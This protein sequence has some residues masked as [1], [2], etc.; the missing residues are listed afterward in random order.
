MRVSR[1]RIAPTLLALCLTAC[2]GGGGKPESLDLA[3]RNLLLVSI[4]TLRADHTSPYGHDI[5]TPA[6]QRLADEGVVFEAAQSPVPM[7]QPA[8]TSLFTGQY[9]GRHGV[10]DNA[11]TMLTDEAVTLAEVLLDAG[12]QTG[13]VVAAKV[14]A[15]PTGLDQGFEFYDD[16][17]PVES[18]DSLS[19]KLERRAREVRLSAQQW[20]T[21]R[22]RARPFALFVHFYDVHMP[23][24]PPPV[25][26][27]RYPGR[28]L[29]GEIAFV[30]RNL[31]ALLEQLEVEGELERTLVI[32][33]SDHGE[34]LGEHDEDEHGLFLYEA[35]SHVPLIVRLPGAD[36]PRGV[37]VATP[38]TLVDVMPT[39]L[40]LLGLETPAGDGL[41]LVPL[42]AG[43]ELA[44]RP[45]LG[46]T[47]YPLFYRWAPSYS[48]R[49]EHWKFILAPRP[50]LYD[51]RRDPTELENLAATQA[52]RAQGMRVA[53][54]RHVELWKDRGGTAEAVGNLSLQEL[55]ALGYGGGAP[56]DE[57]LA[58][59]LP[60]VKDR[61]DLY[62][63]QTAVLDSL[64][65]ARWEE[66]CE[67]L[68]EVLEEDPTNTSALLNMGT[69]LA[70]LGRYEESELHLKA[71]LGLQPDNPYALG[72]LAMG[73]MAQQR[74]DEAEDA[75]CRILE[76]SPRKPEPRFFLGQVLARRGDFAG[77]LECFEAV[78]RQ[79]PD[80]PMLQESLEGSRRALQAQGGR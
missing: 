38:V 28:P 14:M 73:Y 16:H 68:R 59:E 19:P 24:D 57:A 45:V 21:E 65:N 39:V 8:H 3:G 11:G 1:L 17:F 52:E 7:T 62:R 78:Q 35:T 55:A 22:D 58:G 37:R 33:L 49:D 63:R 40:E 25:F 41:S 43:G 50:E 51:L 18:L 69:A 4:D 70:R 15:A 80:M 5:E 20:L 64:A 61:T 53:L 12:Y 27:E 48:L 47:L 60:D 26:R 13:A 67:G 10:R 36:A 9:P 56:V 30:D 23:H 79:Q 34:S 42:L 75:L 74:L 29:D 46:E 2:G 31:E 54:E 76:L 72:T 71:C 6:L 66:A 77:A 32:V 44:P